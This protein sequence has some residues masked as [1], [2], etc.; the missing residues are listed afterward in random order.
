MDLYGHS[1]ST[2]LLWGE[3]PPSCTSSGPEA[4]GLG[5]ASSGH[6]PYQ[7]RSNSLSDILTRSP[8][9]RLSSFST[10][11]ANASALAATACCL[12]R[13]L[14]FSTTEP[15]SVVAASRCFSSAC[16][17]FTFSIDFAHALC[18]AGRP[19]CGSMTG[20]L[21]RNDDRQVRD[22]HPLAVEDQTLGR[23]SAGR[24]SE[25]VTLNAAYRRPIGA[26]FRQAHLGAARQTFHVCPWPPVAD[27]LMK[28]TLRPSEVAPYR[29]GSLLGRGSN[30]YE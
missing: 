16:L 17:L 13:T 15:H 4:T 21:G 24:T 3:P 20:A 23:V 19:L 8:V 14:S 29:C 11:L 6:R 9:C 7:T 26:N 25:G 10:V 28:P 12:R 27:T 1:D 30:D 5:A 2:E 18:A 22:W